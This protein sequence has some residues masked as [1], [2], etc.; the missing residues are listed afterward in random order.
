MAAAPKPAAD[1]RGIEERNQTES[2]LLPVRFP[3]GWIEGIDQLAAKLGQNRSWVIKESIRRFV[4][5][6]TSIALEHR[7]PPR[8][9]AAAPTPPQGGKVKRKRRAKS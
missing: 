6:Q 7:P 1:G 2:V 3:P 8:K 9:R 4:L 5:G